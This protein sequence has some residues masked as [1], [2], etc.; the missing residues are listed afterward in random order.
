MNFMESPLG[1]SV[2]IVNDVR[3]RLKSTTGKLYIVNSGMR[4]FAVLNDSFLLWRGNP[5][6]NAENQASW[7]ASKAERCLFSGAHKTGSFVR[8]R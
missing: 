2:S 4:R 5:R 6:R 3:D 7:R 8:S 1:L